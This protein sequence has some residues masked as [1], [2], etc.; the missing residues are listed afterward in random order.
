[1]ST[2]QPPYGSPEQVPPA[3]D[4]QTPARG[5]PAPGAPYP[6]PQGMQSQVMPPQGVPPMPPHA[7]APQRSR[8]GTLLPILALVFA[9]V[10]LI[11]VCLGYLAF[12][13]SVGIVLGSI[14]FAGWLFLITGLVLAIV[15]LARRAEAKG[16][17]ITALILSIVGGLAGI[18]AAVVFVTATI[19]GIANTV[20]DEY[21]DL[22]PDDPDDYFEMPRGS[23]DPD[24][25]ADCEV[26]FS[27]A[28]DAMNG[29]SDLSS[30]FERLA[31]EM[32]TDEV[33]EPLEDLADAYEELLDMNDPTDIA[34]ATAEH[35]RAAQE[36]D[37]LCGMGF[38]GLP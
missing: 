8:P 21:G 32:T 10:G 28:P 20:V 24:V 37:S 31:G 14:S 30:L 35:N 27:A 22:V 5:V 16:V 1:M 29:S 15:A 13:P 9:I 18:G 3:S 36:L 4:A 34:D 11:V 2:P 26:L 6:P 25:Q 38:D 33:R 19:F 7:A 12:L 17:S 23:A